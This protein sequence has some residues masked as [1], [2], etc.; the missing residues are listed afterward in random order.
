MSDPEATAPETAPPLQPHYIGWAAWAGF[1]AFIL[2]RGI[3]RG[4][5]LSIVVSGFFLGMGATMLV[6]NASIRLRP[7]R[8][9]AA[10]AIAALGCLAIAGDAAVD[11]WRW[12]NGQ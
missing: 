10:G 8:G 1:G 11:V 9:V 7:W 4:H 2:Y 3:G 6:V 5:T 12:A